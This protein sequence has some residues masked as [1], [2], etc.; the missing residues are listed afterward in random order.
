MVTLRKPSTSRLWAVDTWQ[1][2]DT[3]PS[4]AQWVKS[5]VDTE[6]TLEQVQGN[7]DRDREARL[8]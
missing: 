7:H 3:A 2:A 8:Y 4:L 5:T 6:E 1:H